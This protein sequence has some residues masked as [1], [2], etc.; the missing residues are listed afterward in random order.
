MD[1]IHPVRVVLFWDSEIARDAYGPYFT[2]LVKKSWTFNQMVILAELSV[3]MTMRV[4]SFYEEFHMFYFTLYNMNND[5]E[6]RY[7][8]TI[9]PNLVKKEIHILIEFISIQP[10]TI[11]ITHNTNTVNILEHVTAITQMVSDEP[12]MLY[13]IIDE[14]DDENDHFDEDYAISSE[15]DDDN[16]DAK[17]EDIQTPVN[18]VMENTVTQW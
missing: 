18:P 8:W 15:S 1:V 16:S 10:Q 9:R 14:D 12:Y 5:N 2:R 6:M 7:L 4:P 11:S 17:E 3:R 13:P